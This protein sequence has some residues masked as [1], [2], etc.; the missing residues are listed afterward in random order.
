[1]T[2]PIVVFTA[3]RDP[4]H[5]KGG[6]TSYVRAHARAA[7]RAG[8]EPHIFCSS[9]ASGSVATDF[10][11]VHLVRTDFLP[12]TTPEV[13]PRKKLLFWV[14][15]FVT[16]A[17][18]RFLLTR[19]GPHLIHGMT[20]W[21]YSGIVAAERLQRRGVKAVV[22]I[23]HYTTTEHEARG[24]VQGID[25]THGRVQRLLYQAE[26][27][28]AEQVIRRYER[29][30]YTKP[31]LVLVNY[32]A[33]RHSF[34]DQYGPG[35]EVR[36]VPYASEA[37]FRHSDTKERSAA[38]PPLAALQPSDAPLLVSVSRHDPRKGLNVL[39]RALAEL[40]A[41]G[42]RFRACLV[43]GG[44]LLEADRRLA[45]QLNLGAQVAITG[46]VPDPFPSITASRRIRAIG[47]PSTN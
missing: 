21:G 28:W 4:R 31:R 30:T 16:A 11:I 36:C 2:K 39:L 38:P 25:P 27:W 40:Q 47:F 34:L 5:S 37:A 26:L 46:W 35:A 10:G 33:V 3:S 29:I 23:S 17:I 43:S 45:E 42:V 32:E 22:I 18:E 24:K 8:F 9:V 6:H 13:G 1:M 20:I 14:A 41:Q 7:L 15:P 12:Q 44:K 19:A